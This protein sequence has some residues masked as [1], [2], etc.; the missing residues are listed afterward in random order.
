M[1]LTP[2]EKKT[3]SDLGPNEEENDDI[4]HEDHGKDV[5]FDDRHDETLEN[6]DE[7]NSGEMPDSFG[8]D[9]THDQY[10]HEALYYG[11]DNEI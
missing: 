7:K 2:N 11:E 10:A 9:Y 8:E 6:L 5:S 1:T 4:G 3:K